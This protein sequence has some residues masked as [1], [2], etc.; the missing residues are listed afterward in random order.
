M[1]ILGLTTAVVACKPST[2]A[3]PPS[4]PVATP[5][6]PAPEPAAAPAPAPAAD[7]GDVHIVGD[8]LEIDRFI[9]FAFDSHQILEDSFDLLDH[10]AQL[11]KNHPEIVKLHVIGH[12]D[13]AGSR[14]YNQ[15][16]SERR[17]NAV[18]EALRSRGVTQTMDAAGK[19]MTQHLCTED[20]DACHEKN[21][22]VE[23]VIERR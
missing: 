2:P 21:R 22:R 16:L 18:V 19:G 3:A 10:I 4:E 15:Q 17:A 7:P 6:A 13:S 12:T 8:H 14:D 1:L 11:L 9:H 5:T 23:F 20:T